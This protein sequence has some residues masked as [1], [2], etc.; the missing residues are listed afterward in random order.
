MLKAIHNET[1]FHRNTTHEMDYI[2]MSTL[3]S[4]DEEYLV[5]EL[6]LVLKNHIH[7]DTSDV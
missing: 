5:L 3:F 1:R 2:Q 4:M 6:Q 7:S